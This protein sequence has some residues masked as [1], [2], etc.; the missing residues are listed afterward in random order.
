MYVGEAR[1]SAV[2]PVR[3]VLTNFDPGS[4]GVGKRVYGDLVEIARGNQIC[5]MLWRH[6]VVLR[7]LVDCASHVIKI[8]FEDSFISCA[9]VVGASCHE[10]QGEYYDRI[11]QFWNY[12]H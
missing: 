3:G 12:F 4:R 7:V 11:A 6:F 9:F 5:Q 1:V 2:K 10:E 8:F